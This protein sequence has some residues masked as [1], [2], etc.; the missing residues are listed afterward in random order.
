MTTA[1]RLWQPDVV[2]VVAHIGASGAGSGGYEEESPQKPLTDYV[3]TRWYRAPEILLGSG[4]Y[5][6]GVDMWAVGCILGEMLSGKPIF[7]GTSTINQLE[8]I[9]ELVGFPSAE[10]AAQISPYGHAM[11]YGSG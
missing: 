5:T 9:T 11:M 4:A 3:A 7:P 6:F 2:S 10:E 1:A 8:K